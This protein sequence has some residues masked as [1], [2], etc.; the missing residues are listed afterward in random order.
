MR[1]T[2]TD[3]ENAVAQMPGDLISNK[4]YRTILDLAEE[5]KVDADQASRSIYEVPVE[6]LSKSG[7]DDLIDYLKHLKGGESSPS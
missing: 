6:E 4:Q 7:A 1:I 2:A 3:G 5:L